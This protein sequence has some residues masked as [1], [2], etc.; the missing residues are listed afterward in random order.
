MTPDEITED[1][2]QNWID[3]IEQLPVKLRLLSKDLSNEELNFQYR[4]DG[5][6]LKQVIH[7]LADSHINSFTRFKLMLTEENPTI[8]PYNEALWAETED[9]NNDNVDLSL[10]ILEGLHARWIIFLRNLE[11][12]DLDRTY[13]HPE[14]KKQY[15]LKWM[16][17]LYDWH[18]R[19]HLA[20]IEQALKL[21]GNFS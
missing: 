16:V 14:D 4:P 9:A 21:Q 17:G 6:T 15:T 20:H 12:S 8:K 7:H 13:F 2:I 18:S 1:H 11:P 5:W 10:N 19:H 3:T